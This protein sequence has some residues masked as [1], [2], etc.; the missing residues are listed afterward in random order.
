MEQE[1]TRES[2]EREK[3]LE[4]QEKMSDL[5]ARRDF[6]ALRQFLERWEDYELADIL[7]DLPAEVEAVAFRILPKPRA[8][9]VFSYLEMEDQQRLLHAFGQTE[10]AG[11]LDEMP[12]DDR[13][14][15]LDVLPSNIQRQLL[16]LLSPEEQR[17][18]RSLLG[19]EDGTVGRIM[20]TEFVA[21]DRNLT[22]KEALDYI[23]SHGTDKETLNVVYV[24]DENNRILDNMRIRKLLVSDPEAKLDD[25]TDRSVVSLYANQPAEEAVKLFQ[26]T[27]LFALPVTTFTGKILGIVTMDDVIDLAEKRATRTMQKFG[28]TAELSD[29]YLKTGW[30]RMITKRAPWLVVLFLSG[31]LTANAMAFFEGEIE[32]AAVL[33]IFLPLIIASGGNSGSQAAT[34]VIRSIA[35]GE[36]R[37]VD[38]V[39]VLGKEI[40]MGLSLGLILGSIGLAVVAIGSRFSQIFTE[41]W[42][43]VAMTVGV[44]LVCVVLWGSLIG[45]MLPLILRKLGLDPATSSAPF[46]STFVDVTGIVIYFS[47]AS[48]ILRG[49]LL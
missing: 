20:T 24:V 7:T 29:P 15:L 45:S 41:F 5:V 6:Q 49:S 26:E 33:M 22:V 46:V 27:D 16:N 30:L 8:G 2:L 25:L 28:G 10:V 17:V 14:A 47:I 4:A 1:E 9:N 39:K 11:I 19:Y 44:A 21:L 38:W 40:V 37:L 32:K 23:R 36:V 13:T 35:T 34:L 3:V 18:A 48:Y 43:L 31:L 12:A 42:P